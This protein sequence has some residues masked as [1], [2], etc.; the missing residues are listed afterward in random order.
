MTINFKIGNKTHTVNCD[1]ILYEKE[2]IKVVINHYVFD[3][4]NEF[5]FSDS[6]EIK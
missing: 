5:K 2:A 6:V 4:T 3:L 1:E